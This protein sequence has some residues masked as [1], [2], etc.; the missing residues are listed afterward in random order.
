MIVALDMQLAVGHATGI[1]EYVIGLA[2]ALRERGVD[3]VE[4]C[5]PKL[6]PWRFD[7]R[8]T[9]DQVLLPQRARASGADVLHCASGTMPLHTTLPTIVTV[10]DVAWLKVQRHTR[11]YARYYFGTFALQRYP[12]AHAIVVDSAF[13]RSELLEVLQVPE[14]RVH[15]VYPGVASD[16]CTLRRRPSGEPVIL[17][18]GTVERRKN[19]EV[20]IRAL[21]ALAPDVRIVSVGPSTPY[22]DEC[23]RLAEH[24]GV[25]DRI[26][27]RGYV[28]RAA[29]LELYATCALVAVPSRYEGFGYAA[30][31]ALCAGT[32]VI[33]SDAAS[34][35]EV[36]GGAAPIV[37]AGDHDGWSREIA[38]LLRDA[39]APS[40]LAQE[41]RQAAAARF[42]WSA[43]AT[44]LSEVYETALRSS[45]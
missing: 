26:E 35:P 11:P 27:W 4:L 33:V 5:E 10:H 8:V 41:R 38:A 22:Q 9:W 25:A 19:L 3:V 24:L 40:A 6:D 32:P 29:L 43:G 30:A 20:L 34:L 18:P 1:G 37:S 23:E 31:Q 39:P 14:D 21:P 17:V 16:Y 42:A 15:V 36:V 44:A 2:G 45:R 13:S 12:R 7:R 28:A